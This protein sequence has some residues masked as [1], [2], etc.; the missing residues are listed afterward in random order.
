MGYAPVN[1]IIVLKGNVNYVHA[2]MNDSEVQDK[3]NEVTDDMVQ[4]GNANTNEA[5]IYYETNSEPHE[6]IPEFIKERYPMLRVFF[7]SIDYDGWAFA[8]YK[9]I[10]KEVEYSYG[11]HDEEDIGQIFAEFVEMA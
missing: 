3:F 7:S 8:Y 2:A 5:W 4:I 10:G 11:T 6:E 9:E 1:N